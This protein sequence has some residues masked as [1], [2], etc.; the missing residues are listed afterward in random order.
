MTRSTDHS[1][2]TGL[3]AAVP[4]YFPPDRTER[5]AMIREGMVCLDTNV[6]FALYRFTAVAR[7][8]LLK[9]LAT[10]GPRLFVPHQVAVE[11][12]HSRPD[13]LR[14]V[15]RTFRDSLSQL[16]KQGRS[17]EDLIRTVKTQNASQ[18]SALDE[19]ADAFRVAIDQLRK[20]L[21]GMRDSHDVPWH[22]LLE[23]EDKLLGKLEVVLDGSVGP[24]PGAE[25]LKELHK[26]A[27]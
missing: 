9:V 18:D 15:E 12:Q 27:K 24:A 1:H 25:K 14:S 4:G 6:L 20:A 22:D 2:L 23:S 13:V 7:T 26:T 3:R 10:L 5:A 16:E 17:V 11:F 8:E 21:V 19:A